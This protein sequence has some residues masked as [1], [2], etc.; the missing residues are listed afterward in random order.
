MAR[1]SKRGITKIECILQAYAV[2]I[3]EDCDTCNMDFINKFLEAYALLRT[4][5]IA[6]EC[7]SENLDALLKAL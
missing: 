2:Q 4:Y 3:L 1:N 5:K 6:A 7:D